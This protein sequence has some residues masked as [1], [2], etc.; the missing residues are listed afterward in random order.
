[1][2]HIKEWPI[3]LYFFEEDGRTQARVSLKADAARLEVVGEAQCDPGDFDVPEIGDEFAAGRALIALGE[4]LVH[5]GE[6][7]VDDL[8]EEPVADKP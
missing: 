6:A 5:T 2:Q 4:K 7:D 8:R 1:M 3:R